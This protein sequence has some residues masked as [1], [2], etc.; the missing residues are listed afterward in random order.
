MR[1][2]GLLLIAAGM[3][4][5]AS[6]AFSGD[7]DAGERQELAEVQGVQPDRRFPLLPVFGGMTL[8]VGALLLTVAGPRG[9]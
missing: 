6:Y 9:K 5:L 4:T 3:V 2:A 1:V 7:G 8:V